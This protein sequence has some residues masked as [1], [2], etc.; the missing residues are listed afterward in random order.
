MPRLRFITPARLKELGIVGM[1]MRNV[2]LI[3]ENNPRRLFPLVDDKLKTKVMAEAAG[4]PVPR[5]LGVVRVQQQVRELVPFLS[6][7]PDFVIKP[8]NGSGGKG[9]LV[10]TGREGEGFVKSDGMV[11]SRA[12]LHRHTSN[13]LSGL[14][15]LGG[16]A[17]VAMLEERIIFSD[18]FDGFSFQGVP[19]IRVIVYKGYPV[20]AMARLSTVNSRG[21]A[22][23]HQGAVGT[24]VDIGTGCALLSI[25]HGTPLKTH[26][27]TGKRLADL[28]IPE[29][30]DCLALASRCHEMTGLGYLGVDIVLDKHRGPVILELNA[31]PGLAIQMA[32]GTGLM[33]R[34]A[35]IDALDQPHESVA[36]RVAFSQASFRSQ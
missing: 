16:R 27:D 6:G 29:W 4:I 24:G 18:V 21:K 19:D 15:S 7:Q 3:S 22:N 9:I 20:M 1:N 8:A 14:F 17:D 33:V 26:P 13:I 36:E 11:I 5:L 23:L 35:A 10:I 12:D 28:V 30:A 2:R 25:Q 31:R 34:L 32:N